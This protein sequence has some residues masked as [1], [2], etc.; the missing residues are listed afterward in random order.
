MTSNYTQQERS[1][2]VSDTKLSHDSHKKLEV[3]VNHPA[4]QSELKRYA[5]EGELMSLVEEAHLSEGIKF[6]QVDIELES[7]SNAATIDLSFRKQGEDSRFNATGQALYK[8]GGFNATGTQFGFL[9]QP[10]EV[11]TEVHSSGRLHDRVMGNHASFAGVTT[12]SN[13]VLCV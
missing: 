10:S 2:K 1:L 12:M 9:N 13:N 4:Q 8:Q 5:A 11:N 7:K 6:K 3:V